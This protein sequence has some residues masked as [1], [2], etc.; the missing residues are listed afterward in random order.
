MGA[1]RASAKEM[2]VKATTMPIARA[3][4]DGGTTRASEIDGDKAIMASNRVD[5]SVNVD[6]VA[7]SART[8]LK[9]HE[10]NDSVD[11]I[12]V[13]QRE[14]WW[15]LQ[16]DRTRALV[17]IA[18]RLSESVNCRSDRQRTAIAL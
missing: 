11:G 12:S 9:P 1:T 8:S 13:E 16:G 14:R 6:R 2:S 5:G 18:S 15:R 17:A 3:R 7:Q 10:S 4:A